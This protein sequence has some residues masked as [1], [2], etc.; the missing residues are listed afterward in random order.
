MTPGFDA[1]VE[2]GMWLGTHHPDWVSD[3]AL[4]AL[5]VSRSRLAA[6]KRWPV[7]RCRAVAVDSAGFT[8]VAQAGR[9]RPSIPEFADFVAACQEWGARWVA[10]M[11][12]PCGPTALAESGLG[13]EAHQALTVEFHAQLA[14]TLPAHLRPLVTPVLQGWDPDDYVRHL[15]MYERAGLDLEDEPLVGVGSLVRDDH[16]TVATVL[17]ELAGTGLRLHAFGVHRRALVAA[18]QRG[19]LHWRPH[20]GCWWPTGVISYDSMAW[21]YAA[22]RRKVRLPE[23]EHR[24]ATCANCQT[25]ALHWR[26]GYV[27]AAQAGHGRWLRSG[28]APEQLTLFGE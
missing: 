13:V 23:C 20:D 15:S 10:G 19:G 14:A 16:D 25:W 27:T 5:F 26:A 3:P 24:A 9:W 7:V 8:E 11:D 4:P 6:R 21:S 28:A 1:A 18:Y 17:A 12:W 22:R 2:A